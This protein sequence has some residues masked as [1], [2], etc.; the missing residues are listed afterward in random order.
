MIRK[1]IV[2]SSAVISAACLFSACADAGTGSL[3]SA[4]QEDIENKME[5]VTS[6]T[7]S[8]AE[9]INLTAQSSVA[10]NMDYLI[11]SYESVQGFG[12]NLFA[13]NIQENNPVLSPVSAYLALSMAGVGADGATKDEFYKVLGEDMM[14][15]SDDMMNVLPE[16]GELLKLSIANSAW[17]D[18][19]FIADDEWVGTIK[20][21][22]DA[23]A[24]QADLSTEAAMNGM[25][26]WIN[27]KTNGMIDKMIEEPF[28]LFTRLVLFNTVYFKGKWDMPFEAENTHK[29]DFYLDKAQNV[30]Q[31]VDMM[32]KYWT[33]LDYISNDFAEGVILPYRNNEEDGTLPHQ[34]V[35]YRDA[36]LAFIA[37]KPI[38]SK[39]IR[40]VYGELSIEAIN[41]MLSDSQNVMADLKLPKFE[42]T[43]DKVLNES[44]QQMGLATCFDAEKAGFHPMGKTKSGYNLFISLVRQK[45]KIIV[46]EEGTEAAA[47]TEIDMR[48]GGAMIMEQPKELYFNEPFIY[49]IMDMDK[50]LPLFVGIMDNPKE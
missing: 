27:D 39:N 44:L 3:P 13:Q 33:Y 21:L 48:D 50:E 36:R 12:Y 35:E 29:E 1:G 43:F 31:Q 7:E 16:D 24:F 23:E 28:D 2:M 11:K 25:N 49:M 37:L 22:M 41:D 10:I 45:A 14:T 20:S 30:T 5:S 42:V 32:N 18:D 9:V 46:D 38:G 47:V 6:K 26:D 8:D 4:Q 19:E 40:E 17:I 34:S 15:L